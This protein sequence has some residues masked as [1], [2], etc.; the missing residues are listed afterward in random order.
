MYLVGDIS[1]DK[2]FSRLQTKNCFGWD[3][4]ICATDPTIFGALG[5]S[6][7]FKVIFVLGQFLLGPLSVVFDYFLEVAHV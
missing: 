3:S 1:V 2:D 7:S 5:A 4:R 6:V